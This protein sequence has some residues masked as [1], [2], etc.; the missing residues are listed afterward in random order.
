MPSDLPDLASIILS[1]L[2]NG[3]EKLNP[4][5]EFIFSSSK[6]HCKLDNVTLGLLSNLISKT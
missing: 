4:N 1:K 2:A 5:I 6:M 3:Y